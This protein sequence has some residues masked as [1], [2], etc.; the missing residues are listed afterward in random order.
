M[1]SPLDIRNDTPGLLRTESMG[2]TLTFDR[3]S[4]TTGRITWNIPQPATG[5]AA[6]T[7][8]Y[9]GI[10]IT[11]DV[12]GND[13]TKLPNNGVIYNADP[14]VDNNL[15][16]G[17]H[18]GT[19]KVVGAFYNDKV[20][21]FLDISG[22][23][24][25]MPCYVSA[26]PVDIQNRYYREG[27][28]AYSLD[29]RQDGTGDTNGTQVVVL[30]PGTTSVGGAQPTDITGLDAN[31][32][33]T[34]TIERGL[35]PK[36][37]R[38]LEP[39]ECSPSPWSYDITIHG[40]DAQ[41]YNDLVQAIKVQ[42]Q[43]LQSPTQ[44]VT[45]PNTNAFYI[46]GGTVYQWNGSTYNIVS[47]L[48]QSTDPALVVD[49]TYWLNTTTNVL[50]YRVQGVWQPVVVIAFAT[51]PAVPEC[52]QGVYWFDGTTAR[53]WD[54]N[55][56]Q[57]VTAYTGTTNPSLPIA[58]PCGSFWY[59]TAT[60]TLNKWNEVAIAWNQT[61]A[62][63]YGTPINVAA[64]TNYVQ[65]WYN[66]TTHQINVWNNGWVVDASARI[67]EIQ[68]TFG[69]VDGTIWMNP[70][71]NIMMI[72]S[73][74]GNMWVQSDVMIF[75]TDPS[76]CQQWW[77]TQ[78]NTMN[79]WD[80]I[81]G[82]WV[83]AVEFWMTSNDPSVAP[84]IS[85]GSVWNNSGTLYYWKNACFVLA[86][87]INYPYDP[88]TSIADGTVWHNTTTDLWFVRNAG[89]WIPINITK[90]SS[91][92]ATLPA[93]TL[94]FNPVTSTLSLWN[95][96]MWVTLTYS[97]TTLVPKQGTLWFNSAT[98]QLMEWN[99]SMWI[100]AVP[101]IDVGFN[102]FGNILFTDTS[103]GSLSWVNITDGTLFKSLTGGFALD[104]PSPGTDGISEDP[105][106]QEIGIGTDGT[107]DERLRLMAEIRY[108][109]GYP[110]VDVELQPEQLN[111]AID[112]A[113][114]TFRQHSSAAYTQGFFFL[115]VRAEHQRYLLTNKVSGMNKIVSILGVHRLTSSF[116]SSAHGAGVYGQIVLQHLY[117]MGNFDLLSYHIMTEYTKTMEILFAGR[118]TFNWNEQTRELYIHQ[119]FPTNER[120]CLIEAAVERTEQQLLTDRRCRPW[121]RK[122]ATAEAMLIL[123]NTRGKYGTLPG[124]GGGVTLNA[125]DLRQQATADKELCLNEIYDN[126]ADTPEEWG[127]TGTFIF[128]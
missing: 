41:D 40:S 42:L 71:T 108:G 84:M 117:N 66:T 87:T 69:L 113:L 77:N 93:G 44:G 82:A 107:N 18:I 68:P 81:T 89:L 8:A 104:L 32:D 30:H 119:R 7:Q 99:G 2:M 52:Q 16:A 50:N 17:D 96:M 45:P 48:H 39:Q 33:Y 70:T 27:I 80:P 125:S 73:A 65:K 14:T 38:P 23:T 102:C 13:S 20:T 59:N 58:P 21:S 54:G 101:L 103:R 86:Q 92:P 63:Q 64:Y 72:W 61:S 67:S 128:G 28:H 43:L 105:S 62:V 22:L 115:Q 124:A 15:F 76:L 4:A 12:T 26:F 95:G 19:S 29:F 111:F 75:A 110:T 90:S 114:Q 11:F 5:C 97:S 55:V 57:A 60:H 35:V 100:K 78:N 121:L 53:L 1:T 25:T 88:Y 74:S 10:I 36:P 91:D 9:N 127:M 118:I 47:V 94:W 34:F 123:A 56:W 85:E 109:L 126:V 122:W 98:Q 24:E 31:T 3:L 79:V 37:N 46:D 49:G 120:M 6:T 116:L 51:D 106:Y 83:V 112:A